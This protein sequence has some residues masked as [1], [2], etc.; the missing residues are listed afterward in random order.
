M[1]KLFG[2]FIYFAALFYADAAL[3]Q[4]KG[5]YFAGTLGF[6]SPM[7]EEANDGGVRAEL[8]YQSATMVSGA[9]G[10]AV[11]NG[12]RTEL[13]VG[14][15]SIEGDRIKL[16]DGVNSSSY[17]LSDYEVSTLLTTANLFYDIKTKGL[18]SP[19]VGGGLGFAQ[20]SVD[21]FTV[22]GWTFYGGTETDLAAFGEVG[23]SLPVTETLDIVPAYRFL[24][25]NTADYEGYEDTT[26]HIL[27]VG[28]RF[29]F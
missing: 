8:S 26:A 23:L 1:K 12:F 3:A 24:W 5:R 22:A 17:D 19:Y 4:S 15:A 14:Y 7:D 16:S 21:G 13:E 28:A 11:G 6:V 9:I 18:V 10:Y 2:I 25:I 29:A 20:L 27:K